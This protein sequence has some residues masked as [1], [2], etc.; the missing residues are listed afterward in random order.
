MRNYQFGTCGE[1]VLAWYAVRYI[2][3]MILDGDV[4]V[5]PSLRVRRQPPSALTI[6]S[7]IDSLFQIFSSRPSQRRF[8]NT[9]RAIM[10]STTRPNQQAWVTAFA[11]APPSACATLRALSNTVEYG[12]QCIFAEEDDD[13]LPN[14]INTACLPWATAGIPSS[15][16]FYSPATACPTS[17]TA[18]ATR[19][20]AGGASDWIDG[21]TA[22][23]CC[24]PGFVGG[25]GG[26]C[27]PET[28]GTTSVVSCG[29]ADAEENE[30]M[31]YIAGQWP[32]SVSVRVTA[33]QLRY[34]ATD[35]GGTASATGSSSLSTASSTS[36]SGAGAGNE[37]GGLSTGAKVAIGTIIPLVSTLG[38]LTAFLLWRRRK[39]R[40][41]AAAMSK[42]FADGHETKRSY[43]KVPQETFINSSI[44]SEDISA[45]TAGAAAAVPAVAVVAQNAHHETPEW[46]AELDATE[47]ERRRYMAV[48]GSLFPPASGAKADASSLGGAS[49]ASELGGMMRVNRK[50]IAPVELDSMPVTSELAG[51]GSAERR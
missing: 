31:V 20:A 8:C 7:R 16:A 12:V 39:H 19:T 49:E 3:L 14:S 41:A 5:L 50:P 32:A 10:A 23:E 27:N 33:L 36:G 15:A 4:G 34:Q 13:T 30:N 18:V 40:K 47:A 45:T 44:G 1:A 43:E 6:R 28:S 42:E 21:E 35:T 2:T 17:W 51:G 46:N 9:V 48:Q 38:A 24:P 22:L 26:L 11:S 29:E 37:G 25:G